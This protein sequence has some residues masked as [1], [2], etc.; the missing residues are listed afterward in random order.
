[1][2]PNPQFLLLCGLAGLMALAVVSDLQSHRIPN[3]LTALGLV[4]ALALQGATG[5]WAGL[6]DA[7]LGALLAFAIFFPF[8]LGRG[9]GAGDV[10]LATA[11]GAFLTPAGALLGSAVALIAGGACALLWLLVRRLASS[12]M[13]ANAVDGAAGG[14]PVARHGRFPYAIAIA[15]GMLFAATQSGSGGSVGP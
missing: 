5:G 11:A 15:V 14:R 8:H 7:A 1:V 4:A 10:K 12:G 2:N 6:G 9:M 3:A 13:P